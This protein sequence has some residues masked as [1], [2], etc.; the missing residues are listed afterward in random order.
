MVRRC[1][2]G[3]AAG[4]VL[5]AIAAF[6]VVRPPAVAGRWYPQS[7]AELQAMIAALTARAFKTD[8]RLPA[9]RRLRALILPHAGLVY[10]GWT[11]AHAARVLSPGLY[12]KVVLMGPDHRIG[13][14][15]AAVSAVDAYRTP[16]GDVRLAPDAARLRASSNLF[17]ASAASDRQEHSL[18]AILPFLQV[19]LGDFSL[20]PIVLGPSDIAAMAGA[21]D[22]LIDST[23]L[24]VVSS[25]LS[26]FLPYDRA[27]VRD[28]ETLR[29]IFDFDS[30]G[31]QRRENG[32]CGTVPILVLLELARR[33]DWRPVLLHYANSGDTGGDRDR[34][35]GYAAVAFYEGGPMQK[36]SAPAAGSQERFTAEQG[37]ML[38]RLARQ[39]ICE[40]LGIVDKNPQTALPAE[41]FDDPCFQRRCGTFVT[42]KT[43][44]R[45]RGCIGN[46]VG[47]KSV[48]EG[49]RENAIHAAFRDPR[50][51]PLAP[52]EFS[53]LQI[54]VS[55]LS[56]PRPLAYD[57][58][59]D[60]LSALRVNVDGVIVRK[61][62]ASA[63]FLPQVWEQLPRTENFLAHL[64]AKAG[65][66]PDAWRKS[67]LEVSTYQVQ[68]FE[69]PH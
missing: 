8:L 22:P 31:L 68:Y 65:L 64:C 35:V 29:M 50:F 12:R 58:P 61:G 19:Y 48:L 45:L 23:T 7:R 42:L 28:R 20:V 17:Q 66:S 5:S 4:C 41:A 59:D 24:V 14:A 52:R 57:T 32:A 69:E 37:R 46:L 2:A 10:S 63:T 21:I 53:D 9:D 49:V 11:A 43:Q 33:Y 39:T 62:G 44:G 25:D 3:L 30:A 6:G 54:S 55:I 38:I 13:F 26:H 67:R 16:L 1:L 51:P 40:K 47:N 27:T 34:V 56:E 60:L 15:N 36:T 18:E